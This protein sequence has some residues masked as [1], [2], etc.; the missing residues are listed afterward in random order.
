[1][2]NPVRTFRFASIPA[3][4]DLWDVCIESRLTTP[5]S[6][7]AALESVFALHGITRRSPILDTCC[8]AGSFDFALMMRGYNLTTADGDAEML[9]LFRKNL[10]ESGIVHESILAKWEDLT[11]VFGEKKFEALICCGNSFVYAG[12]H[13]NQDVEI[14]R[15]KA[16]GNILDTLKI[17]YNL[18]A[19]GG[20]F[21]VDKPADDEQR[22][23]ELIAHVCVAGRDMYDVLFSVKFDS[24]G[25]R[26]N[27]QILLRSQITGEEIGVPNMAYRLKDAELCALLVKAGFR[28]IERIPAAKG[29]HFPTWVVKK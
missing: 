24:T 10:A 14:I 16:L 26:R 18:L 27:A 13:W 8:G 2:T 21:L 25:E 17:F 9:K 6:A 22:T 7:I 23:E 3:F 12:G 1:M 4:H 28:N 11:S 29:Q 20:I 19:P 5:D 15:E